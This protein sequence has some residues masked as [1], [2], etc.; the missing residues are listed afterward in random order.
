GALFAQE[1]T[2][3]LS[4]DDRVVVPIFAPKLVPLHGPFRTTSSTAAP[5]WIPPRVLPPRFPIV[6]G[7]PGL[8]QDVFQQLVRTAGNIFSGRVT[9]VGPVAWSAGPQHAAT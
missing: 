7:N 1:R 4:A 2:K 5:V 3:A 9:S 8:P 6:P